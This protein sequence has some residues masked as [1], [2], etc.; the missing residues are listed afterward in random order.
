MILTKDNDSDFRAQYESKDHWGIA[1]SIDAYECEPTLIRSD[2]MIKLFVE[3]LCDRIE[4]KRFGKCQVVHFGE[5][6]KVAGFSFT[7]LI[8]TSLVSGHFRNQTDSAYI[9][10]FS[11]KYYDPRKVADFVKSFFEAKKILANVLLR[12]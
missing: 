3:K 2:E 1:T 10:V 9:D 5:D 8:E 12:E 6:E 7:Q 4:M 11:C